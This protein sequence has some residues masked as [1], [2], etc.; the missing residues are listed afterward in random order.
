MCGWVAVWPVEILWI[1]SVIRDCVIMEGTGEWVY[2]WL[3]GQW[4]YDGQ[5][6]LNIT[7]CV[8]WEGTGQWVYMWLCGQLRY[9]GQ[10][11]LL[12][13]LL[14]LCGVR[15]GTG[16]WVYMWPVQIWWTHIVKYYR[17][18]YWR[19]FDLR[20]DWSVSLYVAVWQVELWHC[21]I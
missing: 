20:R 6:L 19:L 11:L 21:V 1:D 14:L 2:M 10:I 18:C 12:Q 7:E 17:M 3:C 15:E 9:G 13:T 5:T 8:I 16:Q 4:R